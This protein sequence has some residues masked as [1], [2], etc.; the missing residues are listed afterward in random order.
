MKKIAL[1]GSTGSIGRQVLQ[2]VDKHPESFK[3]VSLCANKN[4]KLLSEQISRYKPVIAT[5]TD[6]LAAQNI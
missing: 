2:V 1:I 5:L 3:I 4:A 6:S